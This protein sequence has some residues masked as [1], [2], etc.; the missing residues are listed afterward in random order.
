MPAGQNN[1]QIGVIADDFTG[2]NDAGVGLTRHGARVNV[3]FGGADAITDGGRAD[4]WVISTD[5]RALPA[6]EAARRVGRAV[7]Q[8]R[9]VAPD[10]WLYKKIDSTLRGNLGAEIEA[11]LNGAQA[12]LA[13][14]AA[15]APAMGRC[16]R[17][18]HCEV[19]GRR[20]TD[21]EFASDPNT[22]VATSSI[23]GRINEQSA[24]PLAE[25][26]VAAVRDASLAMRITALA[27][28][29][30]RL[31]VLDSLLDDD[32]QRIVAALRQLPFKPLL[33]GSAGLIDPLARSLPFAPAPPLLAVI[34]SMSAAARRQIDHA[35]DNAA[36]RL[37]DI[38]VLRLFSANPASL[39]DQWVGDV[40]AALRA[41]RH[42]VVRTCQDEDQR[43]H[44]EAVCRQHGISRQRLGE[45][46][47]LALGRL[48]RRVVDAQPIGGLYLTGGDV[49]VA[50]AS[51]LDATGFH[52]R[53]QIAACVPYG[54]LLG[55]VAQNIPVMTKAGGFGGETTL[56][57][58]IR[59]IEEMS[60]D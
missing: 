23:A 52:I 10:G 43:R 32:L 59:F 37:V 31:V 20:L 25:L 6:G 28:Q 46:I 33:V 8:L 17:N 41:G 12:P 57:E 3:L 58:V 18:G 22:P 13:I 5:S 48:T 40:S 15:A 7:G 47:C 27:E 45:D 2:A 35:R 50:V 60:R 34:G 26:D 53:G 1:A 30:C 55:G 51:A 56:S 11:A 38:D 9:A 4:A 39:I 42:C 36:V 24:L 29:G 54:R 44:I 49:A 14:I 16:I 21:T 19:N